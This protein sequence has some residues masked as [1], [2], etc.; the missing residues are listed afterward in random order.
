MSCNLQQSI[1]NIQILPNGIAIFLKSTN[2][3]LA[4]KIK[5]NLETFFIILKRKKLSLHTILFK[6]RS[7][8]GFLSLGL[9]YDFRHNDKKDDTKACKN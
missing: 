9:H 3:Q 4:T 2:S 5:I 7:L 8:T 6:L 1:K